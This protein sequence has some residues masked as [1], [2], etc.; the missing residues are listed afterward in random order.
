MIVVSRAYYSDCTLGR[1]FLVGFSCHTLELP[2]LGNEPNKSC[3]P[4]GAYDYR[5]SHSPARGRD[6]IWIDGVDGRAAIQIH[7]GNY[8]SQ[9]QGCCLVGDGV[10]DINKDGTP[11][12][13]NS[14]VTFDK[15][16]KLI[17]KAGK[18]QFTEA[19]K[20]YGVYR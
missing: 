14:G 9:I 7:P 11:D 6:V 16:L 20:P 8:T 19:K 12:V 10:Q 18:I 4:E 3:I 2:W 13:I 17:P 5:I 1:L 15:L